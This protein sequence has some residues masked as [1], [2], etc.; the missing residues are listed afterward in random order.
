MKCPYCH[1]EMKK[2][3][4]YSSKTDIRFTPENVKTGFF[5]NHPNDQEIMLAKLSYIR[6]CKIKL[7]RCENCKIEIIDENDL[8]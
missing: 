7:N 1:K 6:G 3:Y 5:N 8:Q 2:G 4:I